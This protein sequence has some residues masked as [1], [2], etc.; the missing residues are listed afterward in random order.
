MLSKKGRLIFSGS[1][2]LYWALAWII[3]VAI[4]SLGALYTLIGAGF[5]LQF[6]YTFPPVLLLGHW[7]QLDAMKADAPWTPGMAPGSNRI[8]TWKQKSRWVRG[9][10]KYWYL[11]SLLVRFDSHAVT[12]TH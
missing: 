6:T 2:V 11:K 5:I 12:E 8:Y 7:M 1:V 10:K 3:A 4:P 9:F